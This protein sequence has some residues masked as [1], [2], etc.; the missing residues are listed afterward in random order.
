MLKS[1]CVLSRLLAR[2]IADAHALHR[3]RSPITASELRRAHRPAIATTAFAS[4][5][6][7]SCSMSG[8]DTT[9]LIALLQHAHACST[10]LIAASMPIRPQLVRTLILTTF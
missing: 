6:V 4:R 3:R 9:L 8:L 5:S 1:D 2:F 7:A 10:T